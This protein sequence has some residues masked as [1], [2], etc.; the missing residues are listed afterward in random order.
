MKK[1]GAK[2]AAATKKAS[3]AKS[4]ATKAQAPAKKAEAPKKAPAK[5]A[6]AA[7][8]KTSSVSRRDSAKKVIWRYDEMDWRLKCDFIVGRDGQGSCS[9]EDLYPCIRHEITQ[10]EGMSLHDPIVKCCA[11]VSP[12][13]AAKK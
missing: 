2:T 4:A 5:K 6:A 9:K 10:R 13:Q 1:P 3:P 8:K 11:H 12:L 7:P